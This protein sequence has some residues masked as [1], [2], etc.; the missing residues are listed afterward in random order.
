MLILG[1]KFDEKEREETFPQV[2][3]AVLVTMRAALALGLMVCFNNLIQSGT[4]L[5]PRG[6]RPIEHGDR[7]RSKQCSEPEWPIC[8]DDDWGP[9]C[10]SGCRMQELIETKN[11]QNDDRIKA[12]RLKL[13]NYFTSINN[14]QVTVTQNA[15]VIGNTL[16][17]VEQRV[18]NYYNILELLHSRSISWLIRI[19]N[20]GDILKGLKV[21]IQ[22]QFK[23]I[24]RLEVDINIKIRAC[25]GS[26]K[27]SVTY[28]IDRER[29]ERL[30]KIHT[31][32]TSTREETIHFAKPIRI[33]KMRQLKNVIGDSK[34]KS[35]T[36][37]EMHPVFWGKKNETVFV[38]E[39]SIKDPSV[40]EAIHVVSSGK[41]ESAVSFPEGKMSA[42]DTSKNG[43][44]SLT[45]GNRSMGT[46][47][48]S[49]SRIDH[50]GKLSFT[51]GFGHGFHSTNSSS[52]TRTIVVKDG[53]VI[54]TVTEGVSAFPHHSLDAVF[55][56]LRIPL[57]GGAKGSTTTTTKFDFESLLHPG[58]KSTS[59]KTEIHK[60][61]VT[62]TIDSD[63][64]SNLGEYGDFH[65]S[66]PREPTGEVSSSSKTVVHER[67]TQ[68][69]SSGGNFKGFKGG[70]AFNPDMH[71][72]PL[73]DD[74]T[75][76]SDLGDH[77]FHREP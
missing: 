65:T 18:S 35:G 43:V 70:T 4:Q 41:G 3:A 61:E 37:K 72:T 69:L 16:D 47:S 5:A 23:E 8:L 32:L 30:E 22:E 1:L 33:L 39:A 29:N 51:K 7:F 68:H 44:G 49:F 36:T 60:M 20:Q 13:E 42:V 24:S 46:G 26:C 57:K 56:K 48:H 15:N 34:Y 6:P 11:Q 77:M 17:E 10:P 76:D 74:E 55:E 40:S 63:D 50:D 9:K 45:S 14:T 64:F 21:Q 27:S 19:N 53:K 67:T 58:T 66:N 28:H 59:S 71:V 25:K 52:T 54:E 2:V 62:T 12:I 31:L 73:P 75:G 38:L